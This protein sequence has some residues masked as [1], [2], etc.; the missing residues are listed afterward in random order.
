MSK[1]IQK[2]HNVERIKPNTENKV[3]VETAFRNNSLL[4][5]GVACLLAI[6]I[7]TDLI[8][9]QWVMVILVLLTVVAIYW[10]LKTFAN[11]YRS[12]LP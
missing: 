4:G 5:I 8:S 1:K 7:Y 10:I 2:P 6:M 12:T 11:K 3:V 9:H